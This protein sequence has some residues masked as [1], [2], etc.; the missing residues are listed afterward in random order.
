MMRIDKHASK[1]SEEQLEE[2]YKKEADK[3]DDLL[4]RKVVPRTY[5][6]EFDPKHF[7]EELDKT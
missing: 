3:K 5:E 1:M 6:E 7:F 4:N 2:F